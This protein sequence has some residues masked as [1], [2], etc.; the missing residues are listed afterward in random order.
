MKE[1]ESL[2]RELSN[3]EAV[4]DTLVKKFDAIDQTGNLEDLATEAKNS[5]VEAINEVAEGGSSGGGMVEITYSELKSLRDDNKLVPGTQY[6][7]TDYHCTTS[8]ENTTSADHQFDIIVTADSES[9]LNENARA[10]QHEGDTYFAN[11]NLNA[12]ELKYCLDNDRGRFAWAVHNSGYVVGTEL[13][14]DA[15]KDVIIEGESYHVFERLGTSIDEPDTWAVGKK[16][17]TLVWLFNNNGEIENG[18]DS[19]L[20]ELEWVEAEYGTGTIYYMKDEFGN[21]CPYDFKNIQFYRWW[22]EDKQMWCETEGDGENFVAAYTFSSEGDSETTSFTDYSLNNIDRLYC[23]SIKECHDDSILVLNNICFFGECSSN[24]FGNDCSDSS[25]GAYC[26]YNLFEK[27]C[28]NISFRE[29]CRGNSFKRGC[30]DIFFEEQC[31]SNSFGNN[32]NEISFG[33][34]CTN[35]SFGNSC[36]RISFGLSCYSNSFGDDCGSIWFS[37]DTS[38][39]PGDYFCCNTIESRVYEIILYNTETSRDG[40]KY[41]RIKSSVVGSGSPR[42]IEVTRGLTYDTTVALTSSGELKTYCEADLAS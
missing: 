35:N 38:K 29:D 8:Q 40:V 28:Y 4:K 18:G 13:Y 17:D 26:N 41:Y 3:R 42:T 39:T 31:H 9:V 32:C 23:N 36:Y 19:G 34:D 37:S 20:E 24:V 10:I 16:G 30:Y 7:I 11:S 1:N 22:D 15:K 6:R 5:L 25:F 14:E 12:W 27:E 21:E 33:V 2:A